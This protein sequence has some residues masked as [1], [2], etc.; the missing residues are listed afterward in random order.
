MRAIE[1]LR[2]QTANLS[3]KVKI[4]SDKLLGNFRGRG[5][6]GIDSGQSMKIG[7]KIFIALLV[8]CRN[9][10]AQGFVNMDFE[11]ATITPTPTGVSTFSADPTQ[12]F[13]GWTV[14]GSGTVVSYNDLSLGAPAVDLMGPDFPNF[15]GYNPLEG[16]YSV[17]LQYFGIAG[18]P[19]TL[20]QTGMV[21][22]GTQ[23]I[24]FLVGNG[25]SAAVVTLDGVN[26]PLSQI[27]GGR[28]A[29]NISAFA[30]SV[31]QLTFTT[32]T[33]NSQY[34]NLYFDD[35]QF[36]SSPVPEPGILGLSALGGLLF[37]RRF[38]RKSR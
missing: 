27:S 13:P 4:S 17:L 3:E 35:I 11:D 38:W 32:P 24:N 25:E 26:I 19:P 30:G 15:V 16:S 14:G 8:F 33:A 18:G 34:Y 20:S 7:I 1:P 10:Q 21:P 6:I 29:G 28:L 37:A 5:K 9:A 31:A 12:C 23:S 36:S 22:V 2:K